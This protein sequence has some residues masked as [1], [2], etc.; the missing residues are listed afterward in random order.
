MSMHMQP[1]ETRDTSVLQLRPW[2][3][4]YKS[5][6]D[7]EVGDIYGIIRVLSSKVTC[8]ID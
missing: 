8:Q 7:R 6:Q 4:E 5:R 1:L 2:N 3:A